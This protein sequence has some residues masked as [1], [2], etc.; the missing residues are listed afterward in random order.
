MPAA[1][2]HSNA[3]PGRPLEECLKRTGS[4]GLCM[5]ANMPL[6]LY[7]PSAWAGVYCT[8]PSNSVVQAGCEPCPEKLDCAHLGSCHMG[9]SLPG[10]YWGALGG[11]TS[12]GT[13]TCP[14]GP[15]G[16]LQSGL[17]LP[18]HP[19]RGQPA[20]RGQDQRMTHWVESLEF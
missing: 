7:S 16:H 9:A 3:V 14:W 11:P 19:C 2:S 15:V 10:I 8:F 1:T 17:W 13:C 5:E 18:K 12:A 20:L 6:C 4:L